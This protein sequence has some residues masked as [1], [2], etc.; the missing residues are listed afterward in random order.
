MYS[1]IAAD[2]VGDKKS[3]VVSGSGA[4]EAQAN[5]GRNKQAGN[6]SPQRNL[7]NQ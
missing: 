3:L 5:T 4:V 1:R 2:L 7:H 6:I